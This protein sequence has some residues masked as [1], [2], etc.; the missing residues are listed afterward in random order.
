MSGQGPWLSPQI[1]YIFV[2]GIFHYF[3]VDCSEFVSE[4]CHLSLSS[5][6][7]SA[8]VIIHVFTSR[9]LSQS[10]IATILF[11][12][13]GVTLSL[14]RKGESLWHLS[15]VPDLFY[16]THHP[17]VLSTMLRTFQFFSWIHNI[18]LCI[19][20]ALNKSACPPWMRRWVL[21]LATM[22]GTSVNVDL[23]PIVRFLGCIF[24]KLSEGGPCY[25]Q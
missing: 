3:T 14:S 5:M 7:Q 25:F 11:H 2:E 18:L 4:F 20:A 24:T 10:L 12:F 6:A 15:F 17:L 16:L 1:C 8:E 19:H 13:Y 21:H 22:D 23:F 9:P